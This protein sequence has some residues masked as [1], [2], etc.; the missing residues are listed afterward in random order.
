MGAKI[1]WADPRSNCDCSP[2]WIVFWNTLCFFL[3]FHYCTTL[4]QHT[5]ATHYLLCILEQQNWTRMGFLRIMIQPVPEK[6]R[7]E[8]VIG[9]EIRIL[10]DQSSGFF[11]KRD[12]WRPLRIP[13]SILMTITSLIFLGTGCTI[14]CVSFCSCTAV[15]NECNTLSQHTSC[16]TPWDR[17]RPR[18]CIQ[19]CPVAVVCCSQCVAVSVLQ[20][21]SLLYLDMYQIETLFRK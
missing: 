9:M 21:A 5:I 3:A 17:G 14:L 10:D 4:L 8:M 13:M 18:P 1:I 19:A 20:S 7:L 2:S 6:M 11:L 16:C 12:L 15:T